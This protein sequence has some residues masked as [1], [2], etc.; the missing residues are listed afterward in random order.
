MTDKKTIYLVRHGETEFNRLGIVQGSGVDSE[1]NSTGLRQAEL[2]HQHY[3][4]LTFDH[5]YTS[6][7]RRTYQSVERFIT[8]PLPHT[9]LEGLNEISW[10]EYEGVKS[11]GHWREDYFK[12]IDHWNNGN[13]EYRI[14]GGENPLELQARQRIALDHI[15]AKPNEEQVLIC[16]HGRAMKSFL[17]LMTGTPLARMEDF[18]HHNLCLYVIEHEGGAFQVIEHNSIHHLKD[19]HR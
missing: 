5:V 17:C 1:L 13:L 6:K 19:L 14:P 12:M 15:M 3:N 16:M 18:Q 9:A 8:S 10:G 4:H 2:F 7:L 11:G